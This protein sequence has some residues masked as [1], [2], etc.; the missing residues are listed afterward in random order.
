MHY[1]LSNF[2]I[3]L[4]DKNI[5]YNRGQLFK[6]CTDSIKFLLRLISVRDTSPFK[7]ST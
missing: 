5:R 1:M 7:P 2:S 3:L 4:F 6:P